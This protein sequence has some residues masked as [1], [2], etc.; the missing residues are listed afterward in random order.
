M[1]RVRTCSRGRAAAIAAAARSVDANAAAAHTPLQEDDWVVVSGVQKRRQRS[2]KVCSLLRGE[3]KKS[4][5][6]TYYCD[7][8]SLERAKCYL[9]P[10]A[11]RVY[12]GAPK[13]C[14]Q[15]WHDDFDCGKLIPSS[16]GK[17]VVLRR[18]GGVA[19]PRKKTRRELALND[20]IRRDD[21]DVDAADDGSDGGN[22]DEDK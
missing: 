1:A 19:G 9:C 8:C 11:R 2:C 20:Q 10:K 22:A 12:N 15:I 17:R 7:Q 21:D 4:F 14:F 13:T 6:T 18:T 16:L 3:R 5:Q